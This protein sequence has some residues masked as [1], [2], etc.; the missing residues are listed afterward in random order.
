M[1]TIAVTWNGEIDSS[2][3]KK[4][5]DE[6]AL[7]AYESADVEVLSGIREYQEAVMA[8]DLVYL[9]SSSNASTS[10]TLTARISDEIEKGLVPCLCRL[11]R[12]LEDQ[13]KLGQIWFLFAHDWPAGIETTYY[14]GN[15]QQ[16]E[17]YL[18]LNG[19]A[20]RLVHSF[21]TQSFNIDLDTPLIW[22]LR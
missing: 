19:G 21:K 16:L 9:A 12:L 22:K 8:T 2:S 20:F 18:Q 10:N 3:I 15:A 1:D 7:S 4:A 13:L 5:M 14:E 17:A 6:I 11:A